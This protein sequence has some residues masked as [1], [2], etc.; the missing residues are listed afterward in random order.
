MIKFKQFIVEYLTDKQ[1]NRYK[2]VH[3]TNKARADTDHFFSVGNDKVTG[4]LSAM[5]DK[6]EI[7]KKV[8]NHLGKEISHDDYRAGMTMD[9]LNRQV[10]IGRLIKDNKL[11][12]EFATDPVREGSRKAQSQYTTST[13]RGTEVAGQTN[14][15]PNEQHPRGHS[16]GNASCKNVDTGANK[17]YL[18]DEI[19]HG[20]VAHRVHDQNGQEI[21]RATL[22]PHHNDKGD[23]VYAV[24]AEY[25]IKHP[26]FAVDANRV[27]KEL[28]GEYK[29]GIFSKHP[30]VYDDNH[31]RDILYPSTTPEHISKALDDGDDRVRSAA[32]KHPKATP[33]HISKALNDRN[34]YVRLTAIQHPNA[35]AEHISKA[36][37]ARSPTVRLAAVDNP[38]ATAEHISRALNDGNDRVRAAAIQHPKA[39]PNIY[40]KR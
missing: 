14:S 16:W 38:N 32:I 1:R 8:E 11:R 27:A 18:A 25:G 39:T 2:N 4:S 7:H 35:T 23:T 40:L 22:Q 29:P 15:T 10:R 24:D 37:N 36:L 26:S 28:S 31:V 21:Y 30:K 5:A 3:M 34:E 33:E 9:H 17:H 6:S 13:V 19:K 12:D 20:T